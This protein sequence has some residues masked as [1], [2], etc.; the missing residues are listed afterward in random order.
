ME[1]NNLFIDKTK[2]NKEK[3]LAKI[4]EE[5]EAKKKS[6]FL[7]IA[8]IDRQDDFLVGNIYTHYYRDIMLKRLPLSYIGTVFHVCRDKIIKETNCNMDD[9]LLKHVNNWCEQEGEKTATM[10][11]A[12][13]CDAVLPTSNGPVLQLS[14]PY[15]VIR[16]FPLK[17]TMIEDALQWIG[18][19]LYV[20]VVIGNTASE[21]K[22]FEI[23]EIKESNYTL[24]G[25]IIKNEEIPLL[26]YGERFSE[27]VRCSGLPGCKVA[28]DNIE[29][30]LKSKN[31]GTYRVDK[32]ELRFRKD[33]IIEA[34]IY[35]NNRLEYVY[36]HDKHLHPVQISKM[37][38][39]GYYRYEGDLYQFDQL[40]ENLY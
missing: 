37:L 35:K 36:S 1:F 34:L 23:K 17:K 8:N 24:K 20:R 30:Y 13:I 3:E 5:L 39:Q 15:K 26:Y 18:K 28:L 31:Y 25:E 40:Y 21:D 9:Y 12:M 6:L 10:T 33:N 7:N 4:I 16:T 19:L 32:E 2:N 38:E 11:M 14:D 27:Y 22:V 29:K